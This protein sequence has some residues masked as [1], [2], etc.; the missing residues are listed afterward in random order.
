MLLAF[1]VNK[2]QMKHFRTS[3]VDSPNIGFDKLYV[4]DHHL[5]FYHQVKH[6]SKQILENLLEI[7]SDIKF[8]QNMIVPTGLYKKNHSRSIRYK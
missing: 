3:F 8:R 6:D 7:Q 4:H 1:L 2:Y 5:Q